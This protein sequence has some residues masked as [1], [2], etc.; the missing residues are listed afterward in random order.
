MES[1][2]NQWRLI[3]NIGLEPLL[4]AAILFGLLIS[5]SNAASAQSSAFQCPEGGYAQACKSYQELAQAKDEDVDA[6]LVCFREYTDEFFVIYVG[7]VSEITYTWYHLDHG[8]YT[9]RPGAKQSGTAFVYTFKNGIQDSA[10]NPYLVASGNWFALNGNLIFTGH[11]WTFRNTGKAS[12]P[13]SQLDISSDQ[14]SLAKHYISQTNKVVDYSLTIQ[15][16]TKRFSESFNVRPH[17]SKLS[18]E[19]TGRCVEVKQ[20]PKLPEPPPPP[21]TPEELEQKAQ[22][23]A[24]L[25]SLPRHWRHMKAGETCIAPCTLGSPV[26]VWVD[27]DTLHESAT[28]TNATLDGQPVKSTTSCT[29]RAGATETDPWAG[30]C[31]YSFYWN[32]ATLPQCTVTTVEIVTTI[33]RSEIAGKA[34]RLDY[35]PVHQNPTHCP[36]PSTEYTDWSYIPDTQAQ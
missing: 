33:S 28:R 20:L 19:T 1:R 2:F 21:P 12:K 23:Q 26:D 22:H 24:F 29:V 6:N 14:I 3:T 35:T 32:D 5:P 13:E 11:E 31:E 15:R 8:Y 27:G 4:G 34:Q 18:L 7:Y 9:V 36:V 17:D 10:Q 30:Q 16:S 25:K